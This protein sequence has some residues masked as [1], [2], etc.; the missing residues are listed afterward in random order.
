MLTVVA[1]VTPAE[2]EGEEKDDVVGDVLTLEPLWFA[3]ARTTVRDAATNT[4]AIATA[5]I[6]RDD[7]LGAVKRA[8]LREFFGL[9]SD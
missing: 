2:D 9:S 7:S 4:T 1:V 8:E 5:S 6:L 3:N